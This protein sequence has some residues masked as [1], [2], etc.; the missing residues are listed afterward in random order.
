MTEY[1]KL[2]HTA[3]HVDCPACDVLGAMLNRRVSAEMSFSEACDLW[4]EQHKLYI[5]ESTLSAYEKNR[6]PLRAFFGNLVL[7]DIHIG[8]IRTYQEQRK[9][10][11][12][13]Y[14]INAEM[15]CFQMV[16]KE[17]GFWEPISKLY[18]PL[19]VAKRRAGHSLTEAD[20]QRLRD[21]A[22]SK[23]KWRL[24]A[25]CMIVMLST[26]MGFGELRQLRRRDVDLKDRRLTVRDGAKNDYRDR[27]IPLNRAAY[28]SMCWLID[29]WEQL[30]GR[31]PMQF[32]LPHRPKSNGG[33][34]ILTEPMTSIGT[35]FRKIRAAAGLT[36]F[37][38]YDCRVQAITKLL[39]NPAVSPQVAKEIAGH[40]SQAMQDRYSIQQFDTKLAALE[41]LEGPSR[42]PQRPHLHVLSGT[43][44]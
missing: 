41:A 15:S 4:M 9:Q 10:V 39:S 21:I 38:V 23:P 34:W 37:R 18:K 11:A 20:E 5:R 29:R 2:R 35:A 28:D 27:T 26:T 42:I 43:H 19:R 14:L 25:H 33:P 31:D 17:A 36:H 24:A 30:G 6:K 32:I 13:A 12:G 16:L 22:F 8:H 1:A 40:I 7:G 44:N 3:D